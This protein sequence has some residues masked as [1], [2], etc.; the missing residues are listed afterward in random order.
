M[1]WG[2]AANAIPLMI[3]STAVAGSIGWQALVMFAIIFFWTPPHSWALAMRRTENYRAA[4][5]PTLP[6][7][8]SEC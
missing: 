8:A 1:V 5:V 7:V 3:G 6:A 4:G 2:G